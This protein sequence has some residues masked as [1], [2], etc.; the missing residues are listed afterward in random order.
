MA[1]IIPLAPADLLIDEQNPRISQPNVGQHKALQALAVH[2]DTKLQKLAK[3]IVQNGLNP[4]DLPIVM[5]FEDD[6]KRYV[7]LEGNRRLTA[8]KAL[9]NPEWLVDCVNKHVLVDMRRLSRA[10]QDNPV[11]SV[12]CV[13]VKDRDEAHHW[14]E[15]RHTGENEGAGLVRWG[16]DERERFAARTSGFPIHQQALN[17]LEDRR[18]LTPEARR[19]VPTTSFKRLIVTPEVREKLGLEVQKGKLHLLASEKNVAK[20][21]MYIIND[22]A[23]GTTKVRDIYTKDDR[24]DYANKLPAHI[25]V[26]P[27]VPSGQGIEIGGG[28]PRPKGK[29]STTRIGKQR[30]K[31]IPRDCVL[32]ISEPRLRD[33]ER[34]LRLLS[35]DH[36][37]NA[38]SV[39]F[40]VFIEL[41]V[42][43]YIERLKLT[44][45]SLDAKLTKKLDDVTNDL[46]SRQQLTKQQ[47]RAVRRASAKDSFLAPSIAQ[48]NNYIHNPYV[49]PAPGDLRA[50]WDSL[51]PFLIAIWAP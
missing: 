47:A 41:G 26:T 11:E 45:T 40:R 2:Q 36:H 28:S 6:L 14:I 42:D 20:A 16:T 9:E 4:A 5:T 43:S 25:A 32:H 46:V 31:L 7:V 23:S 3:D 37:T 27:V 44:G 19:N 34:E 33:I 49:F 1:E 8:L 30:D 48:M 22:L 13:L 21:L 18:Y 29:S 38:V 39:L 15:L 35:L 50:S 51:Q 17:F 12:N 10:Y 24:V